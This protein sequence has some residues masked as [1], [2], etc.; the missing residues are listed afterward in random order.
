MLC[1][2]R[3]GFR[4]GEISVIKAHNQ[5][6]PPGGA[7][8]QPVEQSRGKVW[9]GLTRRRAAEAALYLTPMPDDVSDP[10]EGPALDMPQAVDAEKP[11]TR[12]TIATAGT[13]TAA[14][15]TV[16]VVAQ[17][18]QEVRTIKGQHWRHSAVG[19]HGRCCGGDGAGCVCRVGT[20]QTTQGRVGLMFALLSPP[21]AGNRPSHRP[22]CISRRM[23]YKS[24]RVAVRAQWD[25]EK[26]LPLKQAR[27]NCNRPP[28]QRKPCTDR[29]SECRGSRYAKRKNWTCCPL[30]AA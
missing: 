10:V 17:V 14:V 18:S 4:H 30:A 11:M 21:M 7:S 22:R 15:S 3:W 20:Y 12:S 9:P 28:G 1:V 2:Q 13:A 6:R 27:K 16:S 19:C 5:G 26:A 23:A 8:I 24:G 29:L 25:A